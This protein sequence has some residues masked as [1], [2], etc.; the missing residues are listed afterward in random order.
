MSC[1]SIDF[2]TRLSTVF[3]WLSRPQGERYG[4]SCMS[5]INVCHTNVYINTDIRFFFALSDLT[6]TLCTW[7]NQTRQDIVM[8]Q[9]AARSANDSTLPVAKYWKEHETRQA[10]NKKFAVETKLLSRTF[11]VTLVYLWFGLLCAINSERVQATHW[12][13]RQYKV[14]FHSFSFIYFAAF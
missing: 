5:N 11:T 12:E 10:R 2:E 8:G 9:Q 7:R 14:V 1:R 6:F 3:E 4:T 13:H